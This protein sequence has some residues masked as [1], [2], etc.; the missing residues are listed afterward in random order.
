MLS[1]SLTNPAMPAYAGRPSSAVVT[2]K[3]IIALSPS[4]GKRITPTRSLTLPYG[5]DP[6]YRSFGSMGVSMKR[7]QASRKIYNKLSLP[8]NLVMKTCARTVFSLPAPKPLKTKWGTFYEVEKVVQICCKNNVKYF[9]KWTGYPDSDNS[10]I[11]HLPKAFKKAW[12]I[13]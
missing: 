2:H 8:E 3:R 13:R 1:R 10:W 9:V 5:D 11:E 7:K 4:I 12:I 6:V